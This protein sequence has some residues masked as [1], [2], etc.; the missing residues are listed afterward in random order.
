M[1][2]DWQ[3]PRCPLSRRQC[4][5]YIQH[6][7]GEKQYGHFMIQ[8]TSHEDLSRRL[9]R[10][11]HVLSWRGVL[12]SLPR[13]PPHLH[14]LSTLSFS[15]SSGQDPPDE[16]VH[17]SLFKCDRLNPPVLSRKALVGRPDAIEQCD[18]NAAR[19]GGSLDPRTRPQLNFSY[20]LQVTEPTD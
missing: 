8:L 4:S 1:E 6:T 14:E 20:L 17:R 9:A 10:Y 3:W 13:P 11:V 19:S 16:R 15:T 12:S 7:Q 5:F 18:K 2:K